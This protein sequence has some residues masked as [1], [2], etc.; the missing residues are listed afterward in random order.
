M[1]SKTRSFGKQH[2][3]PTQSVREP[4]FKIYLLISIEPFSSGNWG[5]PSQLQKV[6]SPGNMHLYGC[7]IYIYIYYISNS[8]YIYI[9]CILLSSDL[10]NMNMGVR[11]SLGPSYPRTRIRVSDLEAGR[12]YRTGLGPAPFGVTRGRHPQI[13]SNTEAKN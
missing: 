9:L 5:N 3:S 11:S 2:A 4:Y 13:H 10:W 6:E 1:R 8:K 12:C 7:D